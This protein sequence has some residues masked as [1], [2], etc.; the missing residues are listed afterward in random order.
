MASSS[1]DAADADASRSSN[2]DDAS[3]SNK[4]SPSPSSERNEEHAARTLVEDFGDAVI[5]SSSADRNS[6][7]ILECPAIPAQDAAPART[8]KRNDNTTSITPSSAIPSFTSDS[9]YL[10]SY[11]D[12]EMRNLS[13][14]TETLR[15]ISARARTFGK[16]GALMAEATRRLS[17]A[18][19]LNPPTSAAGGSV[20]AVVTGGRASESG[21]G[22]ESETDEQMRIMRERQESIGDEMTS[23]LTVLGEILDE[24]ADA[25]VSMCQSLEASLSLSLE[26][27]AGVELN[28]A[29]RL[30]SEADVMS[31]NAESSFSRYMHGRH[32]ERANMAAGIGG[33]MI[34][35]SG[36]MGSGGSM[37]MDALDQ[38]NFVTS[39]NKLSDHVGSQFKNWNRTT[40]NESASSGE[41]GN[42]QVATKG[43]EPGR[44]LKNLRDRINRGKDDENEKDPALATAEAAANLRHNLEQIRLTQANAE[45]KRFQLLRRLDSI[46]TRRNFELGESTLASLNGLRAYFHHCSD[47]IDGITPKLTRLQDKQA[48]SREKHDA[49]QAPWET[50]QK[51]LINTIGE[52][53]AAAANT[54]AI[55][56]AISKGQVEDLDEHIL[57]GHPLTLEEIESNI[58]FWE[59]QRQLNIGSLYQRK[60]TPGVIVEGWLYKK[61]SNRLSLNQWARRWFI[62]DKKGVYYLKGGGDGK[63]GDNSNGNDGNDWMDRIRVCDI[64]LCTV[65]EINCK[66][67]GNPNLRFCFEIISPNSKAYL[68][69]ASG[70]ED[71][72][73]WV[74]GIRS[75]IEQQLV[76][77]KLPPE[78]MLLGSNKP[79]KRQMRRGRSNQM[80]TKSISYEE[81]NDGNVIVDRRSS[82]GGSFYDGDFP[83]NGNSPPSPQTGIRNPLVP[84]I[85]DAN[86]ICADCGNV[87]PDWAS[88][89]LGVVVCIECSGVHRSLGVHVSKVRSLR[90]DTM[91]ENE[92][93]LLMELGNQKV[94]CIWEAGL[95]HQEGWT[96]PRGSAS[97]KNKEEWIK[98]KYLWK[99]F[100][101]YHAEDGHDQDD[102]EAKFSADLFH[103]ARRGDLSAIQEALAKGGSVG[104]KNADEGGKTALHICVV[105]QPLDENDLESWKGIQC[106][107]L[108]I[109]N[110]A[111]L[112]AEDS[113]H[114]KVLDCA[115]VGNG[116][117]EMIEYLEARTKPN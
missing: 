111:K 45:L 17:T 61:S 98:S 74:V 64:L 13:V 12:R 6:N 67:K 42:E 56:D 35:S 53:G 84:M 85:L 93:N 82:S 108:L 92:Y 117:R 58:R 83:N 22:E 106:A 89:N 96:K 90:L 49:Q 109:Q 72:K 104:W 32:S 21:E 34:G 107:E 25:Q 14:L 86:P 63:K 114:H 9:P 94:N 68:L 41:G 1:D 28:E 8:Q 91:S 19:R 97:R 73:M 52:V 99:G 69:Q 79:S 87:D 3:S 59:L 36:G 2:D 23:V 116:R 16:C 70:P 7:E 95:H 11:I 27:F 57:A 103:A 75:C 102:R 80:G 44:R 71:Y 77:G 47:M 40:S 50:K 65:R 88:L 15:D 4:S 30:R 26:A 112:A 62:L 115:V 37:A 105:G 39:W 18:C 20:T 31:E 54:G 113:D 48:Q 100:L 46:K 24:V 76:H 10:Q 66:A 29:T 78:N 43:G 38:Q 101:E 60:P 51:S 5:S 81:D 110:G 33:D 55:A